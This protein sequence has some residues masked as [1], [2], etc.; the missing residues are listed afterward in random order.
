METHLAEF[1]G[2]QEEESCNRNLFRIC[3]KFSTEQP[4]DQLLEELLDEA[5]YLKA[6]NANFSQTLLLLSV[7]DGYEEKILYNWTIISSLSLRRS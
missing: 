7:G 3:L 4:R 2:S 5:R 1:E 6:P